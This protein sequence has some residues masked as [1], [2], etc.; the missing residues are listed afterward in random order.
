MTRIPVLVVNSDQFW[1]E[2]ISRYFQIS[3]TFQVVDMALN[4]SDA[5]TKAQQLMPAITIVNSNLPDYQG[6]VVIPY[7][8]RINPQM[9]I[10]A[11]MDANHP[12]IYGQLAQAG[13]TQILIQP[14]VQQIGDCLDQLA[15][16]TAW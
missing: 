7:L 5:I 14:S 16:N 12:E 13:S 8:L 11:V 10:V 1:C 9:K 6:S 4:G 2:D 3:P 15:K